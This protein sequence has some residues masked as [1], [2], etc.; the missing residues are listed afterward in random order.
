M[1]TPHDRLFRYVFSDPEHA[2]GLLAALVPEALGARI[3]WP[4]LELV[5]GSFV[6]PEL[7]ERETDALFRVELDGRAA[8]LY[9]LV[10]HQ[11]Q[12]D[13]LMPL[14]MLS[15][16]VRV[17]ERHLRAEPAVRRVPPVVPIVVHHGER[18]W[19][20]PRSFEELLDATP[21]T[22]AALAAYVP[23]FELLI[24]D[25]ARLSD[26]ELRRR[27]MSALGALTLIALQRLRSALDPLS[28]LEHALDL[29]ARVL[30]T[31]RGTDAFAAILSY[32]LE[33]T[34]VARP[35]L[36]ELVAQLGP[37]GEEAIMST[38]DVIR[39]EGR[40]EGRVEGRAEG[41][42]E[43]RVEGRREAILQ[44]LDAR[45]L[46][47]SDVQRE[48]VLGCADLERLARWLERA[49]VAESA[50]AVFVEPGEDAAPKG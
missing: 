32:V 42:V 20:A 8:L 43:G 19:T 15:Y 11:S 50:E 13:A 31:P 37:K 24:D 16:V 9:V 36:R 34:D 40:V 17:M 39:A 12:P 18:G 25:L 38:A 47:L 10:E 26:A 22:L 29:A 44:V 46:R 45:G 2:R 33:V 30:R 35:A 4:S 41:R 5:P 48:R 23:R 14:R 1:S 6:A 27:R 49:A 28:E 21:E 7:S 3:D